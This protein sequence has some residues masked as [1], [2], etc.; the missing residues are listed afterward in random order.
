MLNSVKY[1]TKSWPVSCKKSWPVLY[2]ILASI[3]Q[4]PGKYQ[5]SIKSWPVFNKILANITRIMD[6]IILQ[7]FWSVLY[8]ILTNKNQAGIVQNSGQCILNFW[9]P[10]HHSDVGAQLGYSSRVIA[11]ELYQYI[12]G[13][14]NRREN[15]L[16]G[17][18]SPF[19]IFPNFDKFWKNKKEG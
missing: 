10:P 16:H 13:I 12:L 6:S 1:H 3:I 17:K 11:S 7:N 14:P 2:K 18:F 5:Y 9:P 15:F 19:R 8:K 4:N